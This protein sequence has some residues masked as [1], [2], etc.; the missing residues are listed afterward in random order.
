MAAPGV[1]ILAG[2]TPELTP[3][4]QA[5]LNTGTLAPQAAWALYQG[6]SMAS[7][8][9]AGVAALLR[10]QHPDWSPAA[11]KSA[12][13]TTAYSTYPDGLNGSLPWDSTAKNAGQ[14]PWGQ[15]AG[16]IAPN[17]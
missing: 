1:D 10:Q 16:H 4:Q 17:G 3:A 2:V 15:G 11:I 5:S 7:P 13:M 8:H 14:L 6:T 12:L 9:V